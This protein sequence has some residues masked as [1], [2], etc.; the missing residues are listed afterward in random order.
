MSQRRRTLFA[1]A[2]LVLAAG[3]AAAQLLPKLPLPPVVGG[4]VDPVLRDLDRA[5]ADLP[6]LREL[7][8][9]RRLRARDLIRQHPREIDVDFAG[10]PVVRGEILAISPTP[11]SLEVARKARFTVLREEVLD[12]LG[13]TLVTLQTPQGITARQGL[14][15]LRKDDPAGQ[16]D[17]N[18]IYL[19]S[20]PVGGAVAHAAGGSGGSGKRIGLLDTGADVS[21]PALKGLKIEQRGFA[22]GGLKP[23]KHGTAVASL[24]AGRT[25]GF[26]GAAPGAS[27]LVADVYGTGPTG[28][29]ASALAKGLAWMAQER[30]PVVNVSLVGPPNATLQ[31][32][33]KA[34][35]GQGT[36][37]VAAVGNDGPAA[38]PLYPA[39]Y[40][41][42]V[43]V[44]GVDARGRVLM[45]AGKAKH[46]D[47][48]APGS[49]MAA[50]AGSGFGSV[51]G[52][53]FAAPIVAGK[54]GLLMDSRSPAEAR[55]AIAAL[56]RQARDLGPKGVD[57]T[58]G[59]GLVGE[60]VRISPKNFSKAGMKAK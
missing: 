49:D 7:T 11:Q 25:D 10:E 38:P 22:P 43:S 21:H 24:I 18:H 2:A 51:R 26:R 4:V 1:A 8:D 31:A 47:F 36:L 40:P 55:A 44:T 30:V 37:V 57:R 3:P 20:G 33:V 60:D 52:T 41:E 48:A 13:V 42:V 29:S 23:G 59:R 16:Y 27:L 17:F 56:A 12:D 34:L 58:Y 19:D 15:R 28:G 32:T 6:K 14:K 54:L 39:S 50:A 45:E 53:S 35:A 5:T 46:I 9:L